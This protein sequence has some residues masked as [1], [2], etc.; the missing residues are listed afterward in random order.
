MVFAD[1][2]LWRPTEQLGESLLRAGFHIVTGG[3]SGT[4]EA[5]SFGASRAAAAAAG[6]AGAA[7]ASSAVI[8]GITCPSAFAYTPRAGMS[9]PNQYLTSQTVAPDLAARNA[10]LVT[11]QTQ[12]AAASAA[13]ASSSSDA[14]SASAAAPVLVVLPGGLGTLAKLALA[15]NLA[16]VESWSASGSGSVSG[17]SPIPHRVILAWRNPW[18]SLLATIG[19]T[20]RIPPEL[21][22]CVRFVDSVEEVMEA[23][24]QIKAERM[25]A[26]AGAASSSSTGAGAGAGVGAPSK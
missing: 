2:A 6:A 19:E 22:A 1:D 25:A 12:P 14:A 21:Q 24:E 4:S 5:V 8:A 26:A 23:L 17:G 16:A 11:G 10:A 3:Y 20:L 13:A 7:P 9:G 18:A 15:W